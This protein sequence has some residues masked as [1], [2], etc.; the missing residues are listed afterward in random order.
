MPQKPADSAH[1][2][3]RTESGHEATYIIT[4]SMWLSAKAP[5]KATSGTSS[6]PQLANNVHIGL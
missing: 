2:G 4:L 6:L 3:A 1:N 5:H